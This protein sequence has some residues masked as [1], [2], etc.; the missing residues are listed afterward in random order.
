MSVAGNPVIIEFESQE[1]RNIMLKNAKKLR[2]E[3]KDSPLAKVYVN[4]DL[5]LA[6]RLQAKCKYFK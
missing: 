1:D 2:N 4:P 3:P 6:E 5:T